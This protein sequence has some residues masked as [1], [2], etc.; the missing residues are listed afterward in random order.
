MELLDRGPFLGALGDYAADAGSGNGRLVLVTGE[1]GIGKT[2]L[3]DAFRES[4]PDLR[5]LWGACDGGFTPR[6][7]GPLHEIATAAG[8]RLRDLCSSDADRNELFAASVELLDGAAPVG[9]VIE[10]LHWADEATL[11]WLAY[12]ARRIGR[13]RALMVATYRDADPGTDGLLANVIG[14][15]AGQ[16]STRRISLP[17][18]G[19]QAVR[20][21]SGDRDAHEVLSVTG[22]N[23]FLVTELLA[24]RTDGVPPSVAD[25]VRGRML[26]HTPSAQRM[27]A[28]AAVIGRPAPANLLAAVAGVAAEALDE[29]VA[30]G[31]LVVHQ[32]DFAFRHE[33]TRRA[34][35]QAVPHVQSTELHRIALLALEREGADPAE[36]AHHAV[37]AGDGPA[38]LRHA[39]AAGRAAAA[40]SSHREAV[41]QL[42]RALEQAADEPWQVRADL[43]ESLA[44][45][46]S[47]R[48]Q[49]EEAAP[50]W[51]TAVELRRGT[52]DDPALARCLLKH[53]NCLW[54]LCE[55]EQQRAATAELLG[56][57]D[58]LPDCAE[59]VLVLYFCGN[60]PELPVARRTRLLQ[61]CLRVAE[62]LGD[63]SLLG[64]AH[65]A[66][67]CVDSDRGPVDFA[68]LQRALE[69]GERCGDSQLVACAYT[70][71]YESRVDR[72]L[73]DDPGRTYERGLTYC[74]EHEQHTYSVCLRGSRVVEL[75]RRGR[76]AEAIS[77]ALETM[78]ETISPINRMHLGLGLATAGFRLGR[79]EARGW[80]EDAWRLGE[81]NGE[82]YWLVQI[83]TV[84][85]QGAWLTGDATLVTDRVLE[86][87]RLGADVDPWVH[88]DL[89]AWLARLGRA[90]E[91]PTRLPSP[92]AEE[93]AGD[94]R[95]A[96]RLWRAL[97]C[98]WEEG[99]ALTWIDDQPS[100]ERAHELFVATGSEPAAHLVRV[101]L[102]EHGLTL[103][104]P[105]GPRTST[106]SHPAGLTTRE[107]EVLDLVAH[108]LTNAEIAERL[109]LS[110]RTVDHH[111]SAV[112]AKLGVST[113]ADAGERAASFAT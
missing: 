81:A 79:S 12:V 96:A 31:T 109:V 85:A 83:A 99:V 107:A 112:L 22:G 43:E 59:K 5:W 25:V 73:L 74:L 50:H 98:P 71:L 95:A 23:P 93:V 64:R 77:L 89:A 58:D 113:R 90:E 36:L 80:L 47:T 14:R 57:V 60:D 41:V 6:P 70:N 94:H 51:R 91:D 48:D 84:A 56:L 92:Y 33:L 97:G 10:D 53:A 19:L 34:V 16:G 28:S 29:C 105:R 78:Q 2:A 72:L 101:R 40:A 35:E 45:S 4:R 61:D 106:R 65:L 108:G 17:P 63:D 20:R 8:G 69:L 11:D 1:A 24:S 76:S 32:N 49:W 52:D 3:V 111:V 37:G 38:T 54:R 27:L 62:V 67:A 18:L 26:D 110:R 44:E 75:A 21:M 88:G 13:A 100:L 9:V 30:S 42:R 87:C 86:L 7:L 103:R 104:A 66:L 55:R 46:L 39:T 68:G 15:I 102:R 82:I